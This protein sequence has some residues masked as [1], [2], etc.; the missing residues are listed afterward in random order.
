MAFKIYRNIANRSK[1]KAILN[2][3]KCFCKRLHLRS[4]EYASAPYNQC[5]DT[6]FISVASIQ[7]IKVLSSRLKLLQQRS[8]IQTKKSQILVCYYLEVSIACLK[9][10]NFDG[11]SGSFLHLIQ[12]H[13]G[14]PVKYLL[15]LAIKYFRKKVL[16]QFLERVL[17][18][19]L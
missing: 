15:L 10:V 14:N 16:S 12:R 1:L 18:T 11:F 19:S 5:Y 2:R 3:V 8:R 13:V 4:F 6:S 7:T 9:S 17:N